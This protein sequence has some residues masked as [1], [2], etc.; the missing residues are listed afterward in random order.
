M[1]DSPS[2]SG[3][4]GTS[5]GAIKKKKYEQ[6]YKKD[7]EELPEFKGWLTTSKKGE[8]FGKCKSCNK[9]IN[10]CSGKDALIKH[11]IGQFHQKKTKTIAK[12]TTL[13]S[14]ASGGSSAKKLDDDIKEGKFKKSFPI[15]RWFSNFYVFPNL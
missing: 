3:G 7:W 15:I 8:H 5:T 14:F 2:D 10:I 13:T 9:D 6:R 11:S 12:Q 1:S 4:E